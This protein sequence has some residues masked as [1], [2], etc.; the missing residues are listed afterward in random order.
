MQYRDDGQAAD[1]LGLKPVGDEVLG[2]HV[3]Q[4]PIGV[5]GRVGLGAKP[6][7]AF[8]EPAANDFV[9]PGKGAADDKEDVAG[10]DLLAF[11]LARL[12]HLD[13]GFHLRGNVVRCF[14]IDVGFLHQLEQIALD[15]RARDIRAVNP[16]R[17]G[18]FVD[19]V[20]V[21]DA[22]LGAIDVAVGL[23]D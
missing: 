22:V 1:E 17:G 20:N 6:H 2:P 16:L 18:N 7:G 15:A 23:A 11:D 14:E 19:F 4:E 9:E 13:N 3:G 12:L 5:G 21:Y 8:V 10:V